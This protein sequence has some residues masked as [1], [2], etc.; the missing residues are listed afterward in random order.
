MVAVST[1]S[2]PFSSSNRRWR[3]CRTVVVIL[4]VVSASLIVGLV[5][6]GDR[7]NVVGYDFPSFQVEKD[8]PINHHHH[9]DHVTDHCPIKSITELS[10]DVLSPKSGT[11]HM[12]DPPEGGKLSLVCC[13]TTK[14]DFSALLH[15]VWAPLGVT[16]LLDMI[17]D[18]YF[19]TQV[20]L[21]RCTD[22]C[23]FGLSADPEWTK[24]YRTSL[25]DDPMWLPPGKDHQRNEK[26]VKRYPEGMWTYAGAGP[27][28]R[29]N[30]FVITL[31]PNPYMGGGSPWEVP[32][33]EFVGQESF[34]LLPKI[35]TGY[36]EKGPG[37][38]ILKREGVSDHVRKEWPLM[39]YILNCNVVDEREE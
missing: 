23:Q 29:N 22:A 17:H 28:S 38:G 5:L 25:Q 20:P 24:K 8:I 12:V 10:N 13:Q 2:K 39:D 9:H 27:N 18:G 36:H 37:Q 26:G 32:L 7:T 33:G 16:R 3:F 31:K 34:D 6:L 19:S 30:Q 21:F 15:H 4:V 11:R 35:Y 14:G 1:K